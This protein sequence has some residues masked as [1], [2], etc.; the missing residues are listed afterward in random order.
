MFFEGKCD[1]S[2]CEISESPNLSPPAWIP[3]PMR[4]LQLH[5]RRLCEASH[6]GWW[7]L[8][9]CC[10]VAHMAMAYGW[11]GWEGGR[12]LA[13][14]RNIA[15]TAFISCRWQDLLTVFILQFSPFCL[16]VLLFSIPVNHVYF[17][18]KCF[19]S[20]IMYVST[21]FFILF[22][23]CLVDFVKACFFYKYMYCY[24]WTYELEKNTLTRIMHSTAG[25]LLYLVLFYSLIFMAIDHLQ[26]LIFQG[27]SNLVFLC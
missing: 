26:Q 15:L 11:R 4:L 25:F 13:T 23:F 14:N 3:P 21:E 7:G 8:V 27:C 1:C 24:N 2:S 9:L 19:S 5:R 12:C 10:L 18:F 17:M 16:L 22:W 6:G 20:L